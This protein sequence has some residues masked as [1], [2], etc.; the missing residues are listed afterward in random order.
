[1]TRTSLR[2][3]SPRPSRPRTPSRAHPSPSPSPVRLESITLLTTT[4]GGSAGTAS[5]PA[6][7]R[8]L[9]S[10]RRPSHRGPRSRLGAQETPPHRARRMPRARSAAAGARQAR[11]IRRPPPRQR[12]RTRHRRAPAPE[13]PPSPSIRTAASDHQRRLSGRPE[14][15]GPSESRPRRSRQAAPTTSCA[16]LRQP[17][18]HVRPWVRL[19][20]PQRYRIR[21]VRRRRTTTRRSGRA[22]IRTAE[23]AGR[24]TASIRRSAASSRATTRRG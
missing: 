14:P 13:P 22:P 9:G 23:L 12:R 19:D 1:M 3:G 16:Y 17:D 18:R 20:R 2:Y 21:K 5:R 6:V 24:R 10:S 4:V 15:T 7:S 11:S 8:V